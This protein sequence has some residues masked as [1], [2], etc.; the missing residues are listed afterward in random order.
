M[1]TAGGTAI[2][3]SIQ[4]SNQCNFLAILHVVIII[5]YFVIII[6]YGDAMTGVR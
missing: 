5:S 2:K 6:Y 1:R 3:T 4:Q